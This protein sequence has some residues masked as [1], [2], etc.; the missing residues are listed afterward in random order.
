MSLA[1]PVNGANGVDPAY[2]S[3]CP[4]GGKDF[5]VAAGDRRADFRLDVLRKR[6][7]H[8]VSAFCAGGAISRG[9]RTARWC[10]VARSDSHPDCFRLPDNSLPTRT[11]SSSGDDA[12]KSKSSAQKEPN[13]H[14]LK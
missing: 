7:D 6:A 13:F 8:S 10:L 11:L 9:Q 12:S 1:V 5:A 3:G 4:C 14:R 2:G